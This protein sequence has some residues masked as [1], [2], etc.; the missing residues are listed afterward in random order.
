MTTPTVTNI[1]KLIINKLTTADYQQ[2]V[3]SGQVSPNELY[4]TVDDRYVKEEDV[5]STYDPTGTAPVNGTAVASAIEDVL[6]SQSGQ[7]G[8]FLTTNGTITSWA[9]VDALPSQTGQSGK[10]LTT[11]GTAASWASI[12]EVEAFTAQEVQTIWNSVMTA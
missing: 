11:D 10:F 1:K 12:T 7:N 6:P 5:V 3:N 8:K 2:L 9:T 4:M